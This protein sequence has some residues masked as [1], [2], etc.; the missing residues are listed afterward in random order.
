MTITFRAIFQEG[1]LR[2]VQSLPLLEGECV[3]VTVA[4]MP[5]VPTPLRPPSAA[6]Q[7]YARRV[8]QAQSLAEMFAVMATPP[9]SPEDYDLCEA[10]EANR[11]AT[12]ERALFAPSGQGSES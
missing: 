8:E 5:P 11:K 12:G 7:D 6:E 10:L 9:P 1:V 4:R 3:E 2:P